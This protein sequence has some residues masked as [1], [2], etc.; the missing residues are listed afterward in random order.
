MAD[1]NDIYPALNTPPNQRNPA[2]N[3]PPNQPNLNTDREN[4]RQ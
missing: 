3:N 2:L 4:D 1:Q